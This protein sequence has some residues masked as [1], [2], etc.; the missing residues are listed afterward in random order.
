MD[1]FVL[2]YKNKTQSQI[3]L[4]NQDKNEQATDAR[5]QKKVNKL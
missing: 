1:K 4:S 5:F 3:S 2:R